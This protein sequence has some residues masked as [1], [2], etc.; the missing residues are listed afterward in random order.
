MLFL[1]YIINIF[2]MVKSGR[3]EYLLDVLTKYVILGLCRLGLNRQKFYLTKAWGT[4]IENQ[5]S[6]DSDKLRLPQ[7]GV[8]L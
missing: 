4:I 2:L 3:T 6:A 1:I 5:I 8:N 7:V